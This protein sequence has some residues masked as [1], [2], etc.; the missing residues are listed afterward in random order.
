[1]E[2]LVVSKMSLKEPEA[3]L[4]KLKLALDKIKKSMEVSNSYAVLGSLLLCDYVEPEKFDE[5]IDKASNIMKRMN[6]EHPILT[7]SRDTANIMAL[8]L[9]Y[10]DEESI[11]AELEEGYEYLKKECKTSVGSDSIQEICEYL[12]LSYGD[13]K[14]KCDKVVK[15]LNTFA[16]H[17][18]R[19]GTGYE[20]ATLGTL[21]DID[22]DVDTL[23][24]EIIEVEDYLKD[25]PGFKADTVNQKKRLMY[26]SIL[27]A[28]TY[29]KATPSSANPVITNMVSI[30]TDQQ[31]AQMISIST[32]I[33]SSLV[34][35][36]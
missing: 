36:D 22:M 33:L 12:V 30:V 8:A 15:L 28:S 3:Y 35:K 11:I 18:A 4:D 34:S 21:I 14:G 23:V 10:K 27:V 26:A 2:I 19:F 24:D 20:F 16:A 31:I 5:V 9:S 32:S 1:M 6:K 7:S 17:K 29:M 13:I 25:K